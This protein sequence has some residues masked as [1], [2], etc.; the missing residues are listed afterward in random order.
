MLLGYLAVQ[1]ANIVSIIR[2]FRQNK[3]EIKGSGEAETS[4]GKFIPSPPNQ[5]SLLETETEM[6]VADGGGEVAY[7]VVSVLFL[8]NLLTLLTF[9]GFY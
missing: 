2:K 6:N 3:R 7:S 5:A 4:Y 8:L 1:R 9:F